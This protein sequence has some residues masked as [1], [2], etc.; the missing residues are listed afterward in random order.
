M[1]TVPVEIS[2]FI[3][4]N[5]AHVTPFILILV[6]EQQMALYKPQDAIVN[7]IDILSR[8]VY[9]YVGILN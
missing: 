2:N 8:S 6:A 7:S 1:L 5:I 3:Q 4:R 9:R